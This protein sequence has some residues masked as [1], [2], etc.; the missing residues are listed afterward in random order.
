MNIFI[1]GLSYSINDNDLKDLFTEYGEITSAK[2]IM[3]KATGRSKGYGFVELADNAAGQ[4]A[5]EELNGAEYDGRTI[6]VS[7]ARPRTEGDRPRRSYDN[8]RGG[9]NNGGY[10]RREY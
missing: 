3:D 2:V 6:S 8:N 9:G 5:I 1:A 4:K 7:E 10:R